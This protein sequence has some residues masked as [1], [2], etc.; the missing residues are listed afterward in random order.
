VYKLSSTDQWETAKVV[1][2]S[3]SSALLQNP[4]T[5]GWYEG[6][7]YVLNAKLNELSDSTAIP[8][9]NFSFQKVVFK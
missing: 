6:R 3:P 5:C 9:D 7:L 4:T 2:S 8:S 1:G